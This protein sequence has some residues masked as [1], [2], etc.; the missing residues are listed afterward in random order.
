MLINEQTARIITEY[1][2]PFNQLEVNARVTY[3]GAELLLPAFWRG[4]GYWSVRMSVKPGV[5]YKIHWEAET[6]EEGLPEPVFENSDTVFITNETVEPHPLTAHGTLGVSSDGHHFAFEDGT[7]FFWLGDTWWKGMV[8]RFS[9]E[10]FKELADD[11]KTKNFSVIQIVAGMLCDEAPYDKTS[12]NEGGYCWKPDFSEINP[13]YYD[14]ADRRISYLCQI[15]LMPCILFSWGYHITFTGYEKMRLYVRNIVARYAAYPVIWDG[16]G[17]IAMP[18]YM[19]K[20]PDEDRERQRREWTDILDYVRKIDPYRRPVGTHPSYS[21]R[22]EVVRDDAVDFDMLQS[23]HRI[24][25]VALN[26]VRQTSVGYHK[27]PHKPVFVSEAVYEGHMIVNTDYHQRYVFWTSFLSGACGF[28]YGAGGIWQMNTDKTP[29]GPSAHGGE[30][31]RT[32]WREAAA[33]PGSAQ[34]GMSKSFLENYRWYDMKPCQDRITPAAFTF[35]ENFHEWFD[36]RAAFNEGNKNNW[37]RFYASGIEDEL[38]MIYLPVGYYDWKTPKVLGLD[39]SASY[40]AKLFNPID[41]TVFSKRLLPEGV[42]EWQPP[43]R[44][45]SQDFV[46]VVEKI[47]ERNWK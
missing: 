32:P 18:Y 41:G 8:G 34:L 20:T 16:C 38:I 11:R 44:P 40:E 29:N 1:T 33:F 3:E 42:S 39:S 21:G 47:G 12:E 26:A 22:R 37:C 23:G 5:T 24:E 6:V 13:V 14:F 27:L 4:G 45:L 46:L 7:P 30:Y 35:N 17:E 31:E 25:E 2:S 10:E 43:C 19:S 36:D 28:T 9:F 15:G